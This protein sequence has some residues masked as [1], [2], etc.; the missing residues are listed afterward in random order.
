METSR[1]RFKMLVKFYS[2]KQHADKMLAGK[3]LARRLKKFRE[4]EDSA[5]RDEH[6][7]TML[8]EKGKL[9]LRIRSGESEWWNVP[10]NDLAGPVER[11]S[12]ALDNLNVFCMTAFRSDLGAWPSRELVD[13]VKYQVEESLPTCSKMGEHAVV[14]TDAEQYLRRVARAAQRE[15][16]QHF[17]ALVKYY[18]SYPSD[19][20]FGDGQSFMPAFLK[21]REYELE[22]EFRIALNTRTVGDD[23]VTLDIGDIHDIGWY[24]ETRELNNLRCCM[25]GIC[26]LCGNRPCESYGLRP[27]RRLRDRGSENYELHDFSCEKCGRFSVTGTAGALLER[28]GTSGT[29]ALGLIPR[30]NPL[31][32]RHLVDS[33]LVGEAVSGCRANT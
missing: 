33:S 2:R 32:E 9:S 18:D 10:P 31:V 29:V 5:R 26:S 17:S 25:M 11:R 21:P 30:W 20:A 28:R 3:L 22:R 6:E 24:A 27:D 19:V 16:W 13:Q 14:I 8:W 1:K 7:G 4:T 12:H 23:H 15:D